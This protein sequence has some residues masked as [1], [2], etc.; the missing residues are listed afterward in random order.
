MRAK[1]MARLG[2]IAAVVAAALPVERP[3]MGSA[4][5]FRPPRAGPGRRRG[6]RAVPHPRQRP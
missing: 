5:G 2:G 6:T 4:P 3:G 1:Y